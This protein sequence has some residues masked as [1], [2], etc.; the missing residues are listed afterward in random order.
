M[1][2]SYFMFLTF[3]FLAGYASALNNAVQR[4]L[5]TATP[6]NKYNFYDIIR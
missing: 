4:G 6:N 2:P 3:C 5:D 1:E